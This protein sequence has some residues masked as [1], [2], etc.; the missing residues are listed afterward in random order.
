MDFLSDNGGIDYNM[1]QCM[2]VPISALSYKSRMTDWRLIMAWLQ[3]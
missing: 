1:C 2:S 3:N